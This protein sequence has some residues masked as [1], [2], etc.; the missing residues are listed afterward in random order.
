MH[1]INRQLCL[2]DS[3]F[4]MEEGNVRLTSTHINQTI[5]TLKLI[6]FSPISHTPY[7][8]VKT[9]IWSVCCINRLNIKLNIDSQRSHE[10]ANHAQGQKWNQ[11]S[12]VLVGLLSYETYIQHR[13]DCQ[14][15][16]SVKVN[17]T[18]WLCR[19][20]YG[21]LIHLSSSSDSG[22]HQGFLLSHNIMK[23]VILTT[24]SEVQFYF[25]RCAG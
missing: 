17:I 22:Y 16:L 9:S 12:V 10:S 24:L 20:P 5:S 11:S 14:S 21:L 3:K 23:S 13:Y 18:R 6:H 8:S 15:W 1:Q 4:Q 2:T 25:E 19:R 7:S